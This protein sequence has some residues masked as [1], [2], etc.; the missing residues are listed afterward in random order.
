MDNI[1]TCEF[2]NNNISPITA[3][4][5]SWKCN[6]P[7]SKIEL[8][9]INDNISIITKIFQH[10]INNDSINIKN[11][12]E[13]NNKIEIYVNLRHIKYNF[14]LIINNN[15]MELKFIGMQPYIL[16]KILMCD[17]ISSNTNSDP[18]DIIHYINKT[19]TDDPDINFPIYPDINDIILSLYSYCNVTIKEYT[20]DDAIVTCPLI[21]DY[22]T[23]VFLLLHMKKL[24]ELLYKNKNN[25]VKKH[26]YIFVPIIAFYVNIMDIN[27]M[28][29]NIEHYELLMAIIELFNKVWDINIVCNLTNILL[30]KKSDMELEIYHDLMQKYLDIFD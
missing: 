7:L 29:N 10:D 15:E 25:I 8:E 20:W 4:I 28:I 2:N 18:C 23:N 30:I 12:I 27:C 26:L 6:N 11:I 16:F 21:I 22:D 5:L 9:N 14:V 13:N 1:F 24:Y 3:K 17:Y 19:L